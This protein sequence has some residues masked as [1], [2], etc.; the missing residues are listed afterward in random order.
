[1][2]PAARERGLEQALARR[3]IEMARENEQ[4]PDLPRMDKVRVRAF[5][6]E[7]NLPIRALWE[8]LGLRETRQ[9]WTMARSLHEPI[10][11]PQ[12]V[13]GINI[14]N[15]RRPEDNERARI[16]YNLSFS[17]HWDSQRE[18]VEEW[19]YWVSIPSLRADLSWLAEV[20]DEPGLIAGFCLCSV[21]DEE[22]K[23]V[24]RREGWIGELGTIRGWR[25][26][27]LGRALLLHG[28]HSLRSEGLD[29]ALLGVDSESLTG[30]QHLYESVGFRIRDRELQYERPLEEIDV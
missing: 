7:A 4:R 8:G 6:R 27:G 14:R 17:D 13:D 28:L 2:H 22:N 20:E 26:K 9:F 25:R 3:L 5:I 10:D 15:Y 16:A 12:P 29:T 11:E 21:Y 1:V 30:A 23:R 24:G 19:N 18:T